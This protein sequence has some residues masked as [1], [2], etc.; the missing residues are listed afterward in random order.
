MMANTKAMFADTM[1][2]YRIWAGNPSYRELERRSDKKISYSTFRN[3]LTS[4]TMPSKLGHV[5]ALVRA[6]GGTDEDLQRWATA[7]R[8]LAMVPEAKNREAGRRNVREL[9]R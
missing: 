1:R 6:L 2:A 4:A 7:W 9:P 8:R 5:E 3:V